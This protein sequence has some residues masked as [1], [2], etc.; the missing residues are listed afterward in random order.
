MI[1]CPNCRNQIPDEAVYCPVCGTG[2]GAVPQ[3]TAQQFP[4]PTASDN[5]NDT[6]PPVYTSPVP[7]VDPY[8]H[9]A[10]YDAADIA[11][12]KVFALAMY[13]LGPLGILIALLA[14]KESRYTA[15]HVRQSLKLTVA[16][17]LGTIALA[18]AAFLMWSLRMRGLMSFIVT[19]AL[20]GLIAVRLL[21][22][23]CVCKNKVTEAFL[24]R[25]LR[26]LK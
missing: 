2:V 9:T 26:F 15:F 21:C 6:H 17:V 24:V 19:V 25:S 5:A 10:D 3:F 7:Y 20:I 1:T 12:N 14:A 4:A 23:L 8:D 22:V 11:E 13:L 18:V 16:E